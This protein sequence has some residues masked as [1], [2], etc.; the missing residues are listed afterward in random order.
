MKY[1]NSALFI[2]VLLN[3]FVCQS[4]DDPKAVDK[5]STLKDY[6]ETLRDVKV[7]E[8]EELKDVFKQI[9]Y[10][11]ATPEQLKN[12]TIIAEVEKFADTVFDKLANKE[13][14]LLILEE[15]VKYFDH[16]IIKEYITE[17]LNSLSMKEVIHT[18]LN[19]IVSMITKMLLSLFGD[20]DL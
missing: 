3:I 18:I 11:V 17:F 8:R 16:N 9:Y 4:N 14:N 13:K 6:L 19:S 2:L 12:E 5:N 10:R 7:F 1:L 20:E 15:A